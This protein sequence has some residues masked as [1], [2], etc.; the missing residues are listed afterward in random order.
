MAFQSNQTGLRVAEEATPKVLPG[1]PIWHP[2]EPNSYD[3]FGGESKTVQR[4]P[5]APDRQRRKGTV[6]DLDAMAG[7]QV[8]LTDRSLGPVLQGFMVAS[9]RTKAELAITAVTGTGYTVAANGTNFVAGDLLFAQACQTAGNNGLKSVTASTSTSVSVAGCA[10]E[11]IVAAELPLIT[12]VGFQFASADL[13]L[14]VSGGVATIGATAKNLTQLGLIPGEWFFVGGDGAAFAF[15]TAGNNGW[16]RAKTISATQIACDRYPDTAATDAGTGKTMRVFIGNALKNESLAANQVVRTY[17]FERTIDAAATKVEYILGC[18]PN[19]LKMSAK[20]TDKMTATVD[21]KG[22][23]TSNAASQKAGTRPSVK[24]QTAFSTSSDFSRLRLQDNASGAQLA[25]YLTDLEL[26]IDNGVDVDKALGTLGG[27]EH[28][29][30]DFKVSG[31]LEAYFTTFA[32][33]DAVKA[34]NSV[35]VDTALVTNVLTPGVGYQAT[36]LLFDVPSIDLGD[37]KLKIEKDKKVKLPLGLEATADATYNHT[38]LLV[39]F[40]Y[41][42]QLAL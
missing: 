29:L 10:V 19:T 35:S 1:T 17:Q 24:P 23:D 33:I 41:L 34:A 30:G 32:A 28:S 6:V 40:P 14:A 11:A 38:L 42:P 27:L 15:A 36:G 39:Y 9:W 25:V 20:T 13:T 16:Y 26:T 21:F 3:D 31:S 7:Y 4:A 5:I 8:D 22:L 2:V 18:C 37:G 12:K